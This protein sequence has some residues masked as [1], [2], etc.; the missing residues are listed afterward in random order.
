MTGTSNFFQKLVF[1]IGLI[2]M[3]IVSS[4]DLQAQSG[5]SGTKTKKNS[6]TTNKGYQTKIQN[7]NKAGEQ[8]T[9][10]STMG[11]AI[12]AH[13]GEIA[14]FEGVYY[15]YGTSYGCG[16]EWG[17]KEAPF[18]GFKTYSSTDLVHWTDR[19]MLFD[20]KTP[21]WQS[22]CDGSTYG[23]FRPH[24]I[25]NKKTSNYVLWINVYDNVSGF[26][27]FTSKSP[28][29]PFTEMAEPKLAVNSDAPAAGLNNGDHD[30][31]VDHDGTGYI[32]YTDWRTK[33]TI[34]IEKLSDDYLTGTGEVTKNITPGKTEAPSVFERNGIYYLTYSDPNCGYCAGTG[35]SYRTA[36][37]PLGPW[38][39]GIQISSNSCGGQPSFVSPIQLTSGTVY[40]YGSDLW[41]D[42]AKN[43][44][45]A[46]FYWAPLA[47]AE[48][49]S[50][51]PMS[52]QNEAELSLAK[53]SK[54]KQEDIK[55]LDN[56]AGIKNF[57]TYEDISQDI[58]RGQGFTATRTGILN[59]ISVTTFQNGYPD[60]DLV[61][62]LYAADDT[63]L[64][65]GKPLYSTNISRDRVSWS[66]S[67][68]TVNPNISVSK[69]SK[70]TIVLKSSS[71]KGIYGFMYHDEGTGHNSGASYSS[72]QGRNYVIEKNRRIKFRTT[73]KTRS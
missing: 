73:I 28:V 32:A 33:G 58:Q 7:F 27:V 57:K 23:C 52:C 5:K 43:E 55:D 2:S 53:G 44:A 41:N 45:L 37:T 69:G 56:D 20:P 13:D 35:T 17:K 48:D 22:R 51:L 42:A 46:N 15:L 62:M 3:S 39:E 40:I 50:I 16:F 6:H 11:E 34:V 70:Y 29:G 21:V 71:K 14:F 10:F 36:K 63:Y 19:G 25:F 49:G 59:G 38:S 67:N 31:F 72:D 9:R 8:V 60:A 64:P 47:F 4:S 54:G 12:D 68:V 26:R 66:P 18:C 1:S 30:T 65:K 24:V 61:I